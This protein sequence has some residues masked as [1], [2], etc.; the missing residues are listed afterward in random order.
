[1][2]EAQLRGAGKLGPFEAL[3][4]DQPLGFDHLGQGRELA[5]RKPMARGHRGIIGGMIDD[6][7]HDLYLGPRAG[8]GKWT[9]RRIMIAQSPCFR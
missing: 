2:G 3:R 7:R 1:M 9:L 4:S 8:E 6:G 5:H